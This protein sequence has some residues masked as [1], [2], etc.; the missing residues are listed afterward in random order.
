ME[1]YRAAARES[2]RRAQNT[3]TDSYI[4]D[5]SGVSTNPSL[6][7]LWEDIKS[8]DALR[9]T[10]NVSIKNINYRQIWDL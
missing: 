4:L 6:K 2:V 9:T 8:N 7:N 5:I 3:Q 10:E 1:T